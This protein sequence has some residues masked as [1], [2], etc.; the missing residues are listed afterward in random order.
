VP[1]E[2]KENVYYIMK[3]NN[4]NQKKNSFPDDCGVWDSSSGTS[5][6]SYLLVKSAGTL[7]SIY[8]RKGIYCIQRR[9]KGK[10]V[11]DEITHQPNELEIIHLNR[12]YVSLK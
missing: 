10:L 4:S 5:P 8:A 1:S 9:N 7:R 2:K 11:Y 6:K 3:L 12:Y